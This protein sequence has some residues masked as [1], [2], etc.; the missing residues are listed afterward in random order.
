VESN[1]TSPGDPADLEE[2]VE[3]LAGDLAALINSAKGEGRETLRELALTIVREDV[4]T[5]ERDAE[6]A[7][8]AGETPA[9][10]RSSS[11]PAALAIPFFLMGCVTIF[12]F[13]PVGLVMFGLSGGLVVAGIG[14]SMFSR[15]GR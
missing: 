7:M 9:P 5:R 1:T 2:R 4:R 13:P 10:G 6:V 8:E 12:L 11:N 14:V 3:S 15:R